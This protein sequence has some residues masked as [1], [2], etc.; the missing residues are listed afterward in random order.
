MKQTQRTRELLLKHYQKYPKLQIKDLFKYT[1]QSA[2]GCEHMVSSLDTAIDYIR[3]EASDISQSNNIQNDDLLIDS[4]DGAY[5]RVYLAYLNHGLSIETLGKLFYASAKKEPSGQSDLKDK[6]L[7]AKELIRENA[8]PFSLDEFEKASKEWQAC[9]YPAVHH[10]DVFRTAYR[11]AY[12]VIANKY[13]P[14]LPLFARLDEMLKNDS[15]VIAI[16]GGSASGKTTLA[17][18][19]KDFYD[20]NI[21]HMDDFF[22]RP[23]QRTPE[24]YTEVGG[25]IDRE[26]F[27]EEVLTPLRKNEPINYQKFDCSTM[28]LL[29]SSKITPK[30]LTII[31]GVY[32]MHPEFT[33]YY[34]LCVFL[35]ISPELQRKRIEKRNSTQIAE[36]YYNEWIPLEK[37]YFS[38]MQ[39]KDRSDICIVG[40]DE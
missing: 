12:R 8:L 38:E 33:E 2:F 16:D 39:V 31:E 36:R 1:H 9:G 28:E 3:K 6:L 35:D 18:M 13:V 37:S 40:G 15:I 11:P 27:L 25:N 20:C 30:R 4:L 5:S 17:E 32:S 22:L 14:F 7:V 34:D 10:S 24:R 19:L 23:E 21:L 29:P 26:R